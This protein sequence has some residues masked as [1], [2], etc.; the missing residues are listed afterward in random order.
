M[1]WMGTIMII[2]ITGNMSYEGETNWLWLSPLEW[3]KAL[4]TGFNCPL[5]VPYTKLETIVPF[6][7][8]TVYKALI[9]LCYFYLLNWLW[10]IE[11]LL[12]RNTI[13]VLKKKTKNVLHQLFF[14]TEINFQILTSQ[15]YLYRY[16]CVSYR[17]ECNETRGLHENCRRPPPYRLAH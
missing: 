11:V 8:C 12:V 3:S 5:I 7:G 4:K 16:H 9:W 1:H 2:V 10:N 13:V 15:L 14:F 17:R 6:Y